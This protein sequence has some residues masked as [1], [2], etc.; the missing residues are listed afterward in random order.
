MGATTPAGHGTAGGSGCPV[1][2]GGCSLGPC[3]S[4]TGV[5]DGTY[6][7]ATTKTPPPNSS[8]PE[9][10][11]PCEGGSACRS[12]VADITVAGGSVSA[13]VTNVYPNNKVTTFNFSASSGDPIVFHDFGLAAPGSNGNSQCDGDSDADDH[14]TGSPSGSCAFLPESAESSACQPFPWSCTL[15]NAGPPAATR[16]LSLTLPATMAAFASAPVTVTALNGTATDPTFVGTV[17]LSSSSD[18]LAVLPAAYTFT[19]ADT[20]VHTFDVTFR[21]PGSQMLTAGGGGGKKKAAGG[22]AAGSGTVTVTND[23]SSF[24]ADLYHDILGRLGGDSEI[25]FWAGQLGHGW[26]REAVAAYFSTSPEVHGRNVDAAY[27]LLLGHAADKGGHDFWVSQLRGGAYDEQLLGMLAATP[28]YYNGH[29]KGTDRGFLSALYQDLLGRTPS[30]AELN[31]WMGGGAIADRTGVANGFAFSHEH[32][33]R[34]VAATTGWYQHY[35]GRPADPDG[36]L[37]WATQ[38]DQGTH[39]QVGVATFTSGDEYYAKAVAY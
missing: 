23:D 19:A 10:Y 32:H 29:G 36:A 37:Y 39:D 1:P 35:L 9:G 24:V 34:L 16:R 27:Q 26:S 33:L 2:T 28:I 3:T 38:L 5:P 30:A 25:G 31:G 4:F 14:S 13:T 22:I 11:A 8:N 21:H 15:G 12:Q 7:I 18:P 6:R 20:G 17:S